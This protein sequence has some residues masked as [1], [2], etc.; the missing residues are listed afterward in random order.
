LDADEDD[1][2]LDDRT[3]TTHRKSKLGKGKTK[4]KGA[5]L[6]D[7]EKK[8]KYLIQG[9]IGLMLVYLAFD[10]FAEEPAPS[11][12]EATQSPA[13]RAK[14]TETIEET[15]AEPPV[16]E[17]AAEPPVV[18][19]AAEPPVVETAVEPPVVETPAE[20]TVAETPIETPDLNWE[21]VS[22]SQPTDGP[23]VG[24]ESVV[25]DSVDGEQVPGADE[26]LTDKILQDLEKQTKPQLRRVVRDY[27]MPPD[28]EYRGR[29]LVYN[30]VGKHWAC[31]DG[32]SYKSCE[33]NM[34]SVK[35]LERKTEC[36]PF[37]VYEGQ[38]SCELMQGRMVS[39]G[40]KTDFCN[41]N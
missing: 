37:N 19:T 4:G 32:P 35:F 29:G 8:R 31:I 13:P 27:V 39:S 25:T 33:D 1:E 21:G 23:T 18:E 10:Y 16:A 11:V 36:Y 24:G 14:K 17:T 38:R 20:P 15:A 30:C 7:A 3:S 40:A 12:S 5:G 22:T 41:E 6:S 34:A 9:V 28:Y 2:D 26:D